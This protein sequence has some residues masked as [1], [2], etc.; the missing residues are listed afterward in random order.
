MVR[1]TRSKTKFIK[2]VRE[3]RRSLMIFVKKTKYFRKKLDH[4]LEQRLIFE[5]IP[6]I[7]ENSKISRTVKKLLRLLFEIKPW[8]DKVL[9]VTQK[10]D[11]LTGEDVSERISQ[12]LFVEVLAIRNAVGTPDGKDWDDEFLSEAEKFHIGQ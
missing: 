10:H 5:E 11:A 3:S 8:A 7:T 2:D 1:T 12:G 4:I 6:E 9:E